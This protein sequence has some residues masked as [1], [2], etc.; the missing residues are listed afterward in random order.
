MPP[1]GDTTMSE[2][3]IAPQVNTASGRTLWNTSR[4]ALDAIHAEL[5]ERAGPALAEAHYRAGPPQFTEV[6]AEALVF[7]VNV[8]DQAAAQARVRESMERYFE[9]TWLHRPRVALQG[10]PP[11]DAAGA[12]CAALAGVSQRTRSARRRAVGPSAIA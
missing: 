9:E 8:S 4:P 10:V 7:P 5:R 11:V 6:G 3:A 12:T 1:T 2:E